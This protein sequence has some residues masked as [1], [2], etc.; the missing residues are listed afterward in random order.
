[1]GIFLLA[2]PLLALLSDRI[3]VDADRQ[4]WSLTTVSAKVP[5]HRGN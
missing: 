4:Y 1:M 2:L 5:G 3:E